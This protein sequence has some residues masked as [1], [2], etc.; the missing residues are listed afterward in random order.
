MAILT[1][2]PTSAYPTI[3]LAMAA[4]AP[5]DTLVLEPGYSNDSATVTH[6][7]ITVQGANLSLGIQL[8]LAPSV[9][10]LH[11]D[12][13]AP[14]SVLDNSGD[15]IIA[16]GSGDN[17]F[18]VTGGTDYV[19]G[20][21]G[22]DQLIV[23][24]HTETGPVIGTSDTVFTDASGRSVTI[25]AGTIEN[26]TILAGSGNNTLTTGAGDD[27]IEA[28]GAGDNTIVTGEGNNTVIT[29]GG[30]DT[31]TMGSG[32]DTVIAGDG[33]NT[34][35]GTG[36]DKVIATGSGADTITLTN[37]NNQIEA[38]DGANTIT[39]TTGNNI[40]EVG[41]G[42]D[43]VTVTSGNNQICAGD[44]A[45]TITATSGD[46]EIC[47]GDGADTI[48][49]TLGNNTIHAGNGVNTVTITS[50]NNII[51]GGQDADTVTTTGNASGS[52]YIDVGDGVNTVTTTLGNDT[53]I[54]GVHTDTIITEAGNDVVYVKGG[55]DS[56]ATGGG[57]DTLVVDYSA[58][59][60]SVTTGPLA[61]VGA[62]GYAGTVSQGLSGTVT[63]AGVEN[64]FIES[65]SG[66]DQLTTGD[67]DDTIDSGIGQDHVHAG[68]GSDLIHSGYD[69]TVDGGDGNDTLN[70]N[71][72]GLHEIVHD[73]LNAQNG[74]VFGLDANGYRTGDE[75]SFTNIEHIVDVPPELP[76]DV[77]VDVPDC[78]CVACF[79]PGTMIVTRNGIVAVEA[80]AKG[81]FVLTRDN[82]FKPIVWIGR[83]SLSGAV[84][85][86]DKT[87][88]PILIR[89]DALG[90]DSPDRD[91]MVSPQHRMLMA[92][93]RA[94]LLF[95]SS[96][97]LVKAKHLIA[98]PGVEVLDLPEVTYLH[99]MFDQHEII[100][101]D[102]A[103]SESF[104]P[105]D[106]T[107]SGLDMDQR[108][109]LVKVFPELLALS[110]FTEYE[111]AR[112]TLK[113]HEARLFL[114][115]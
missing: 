113:S 29:G 30:V 63:F 71:G 9:T 58:S 31:I 91:M 74:T 27:R 115:A 52:N 83:K 7:D 92:R 36:G 37:G 6:S 95:G 100:L 41:S 57:S 80:L 97:V 2:G 3:D 85:A 76:T 23:D 21:A 104:Q 78:D 16:G 72:I 103:W 77:I 49:V 82:G 22:T 107:I 108:Y 15:N 94:E 55:T 98:L 32:N 19:T 67:G 110:R 68:S 102:G 24:Y 112:L 109:E 8:H 87:L 11:L 105:G 96:E 35:A 5:G 38:G 1:V 40:I 93:A 42:A 50:G 66:N 51:I 34:I 73:P 13:T 17:T 45:N 28:A 114:A 39:A 62:A 53:V 47:A 4:A 14:I 89:R 88:Q 12:G 46:N 90:P 48:T 25:E 75:I 70:I 86:K 69:D 26:F 18:T 43:T 61:G 111:A 65:G 101:S 10:G 56:V 33:A 81:D 59:T 64:F 54:S 99:L 106:R 84:L 44:G 20:G 60:N 79:T